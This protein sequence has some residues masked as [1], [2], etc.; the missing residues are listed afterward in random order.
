MD[1]LT[2]EY[3]TIFFYGLPVFVIVGKLFF[4]SIAGFFDC[5]RW[6]LM[7]DLVSLLRGQWG[8]DQ[9]A[10]AKIFIYLALGGFAMYSAH[11][12]FYPA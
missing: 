10:T 7:P 2:R 8:E 6:L 1:T 12:H 3:L 5:L 11:Q 4:G 9:W